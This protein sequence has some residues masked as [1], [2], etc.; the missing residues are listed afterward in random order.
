M[1]DDLDG[2]HNPDVVYA[3]N[4]GSFNARVSRVSIH[5]SSSN[6]D[7]A[8]DFSSWPDA[9]GLLTRDVD[10]DHDDDLVVTTG[11]RRILAV[12]LNDGLGSFRL[13]EGQQFLASLDDK[14]AL[15]ATSYHSEPS[16]AFAENVCSAP[17]IGIANVLIWPPKAP[18]LHLPATLQRT[19]PNAPGPQPCPIRAP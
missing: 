17:Y 16:N 4:A 3:L 2:D 9:S 10:G 1:V 6:Y 15:E 12:F 13:Q 11:V 8:L 18:E 14:D 7:Q 19:V 5:L